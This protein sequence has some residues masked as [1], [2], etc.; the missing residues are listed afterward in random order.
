MRL[1]EDYLPLCHKGKKK[2]KKWVVVTRGTFLILCYGVLDMKQLSSSGVMSCQLCPCV[3]ISLRK[4]KTIRI[5]TTHKRESPWKQ[6]TTTVSN[7]KFFYKFFFILF[8]H[9]TSDWFIFS[10]LLF[11]YY[12][13]KCLSAVEVCL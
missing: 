4:G 2:T 13:W 1:S 12:F 9:I 11:T 5:L 7:L 8:S 6:G 3:Q 10:S